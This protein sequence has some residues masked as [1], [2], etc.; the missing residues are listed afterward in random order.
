MAIKK[1]V[2]F[3]VG[4]EIEGEQS[5]A[6]L[7]LKTDGTNTAVRFR[8][9]PYFY[10]ENIKPDEIMAAQVEEEESRL[11]TA[12]TVEPVQLSEKGEKTLLKVH[13]RLPGDVPKLKDY[14]RKFSNATCYEYDIP[15]EKRVVI[16]LQLI[17]FSR[18]EIDV[19]GDSLNGIRMVEESPEAEWK[20]FAFDMEVYNPGIMPDPRKDPIIMISYADGEENKVIS[21][22]GKGESVIK[23]SSEEAL[24]SRFL[25]TV[26][27][28]DPDMVMGY[29]TSVFDIPY[30]LER[31]AALKI[32][33]ASL[34]RERGKMRKI[35]R[36]NVKG[37]DMTGR[38]HLDLYPM[39][40]L[41]GRIGVFDAEK[42]TLYDV[43]KAVLGKEKLMVD[44]A[45]IWEIWDNPEKTEEL[46]KYS[47]MDAQSTYELGMA[48][49]PLEMEI[50]RLS[51][52]FIFDASLGTT[53]QFVENMLMFYARKN[54]ILIPKK[55]NE[56]EVEKRLA[57]PIEGA[58]VKLPEPGIYENIAV[59]D[60][61]GLYPS[62]ITTYNV[63]PYEIRETDGDVHVSPSGTKFAKGPLGLVPSVLK[64]ILDLRI[65]LKGE[66]K[67]AK[68]GT[69]EHEA[70]KA[71]VQA[72]KII[73][74]SFYGYL[75]YP[76]SRWYSRECASSVTAWGR[77]HIKAAEAEA[78]RLGFN[79]LYM[80]T[81]SLFIL[82]NKKTEKD[83]LDFLG[84]MN[85][86]L[87]GDMKLELEE[88]YTRG[89]FV[90]KKGKEAGAKKKYAMLSKNGKIKIRG[91]ELVR[92]DW[93][94]I[95]RE[96]QRAVLDIILREGDKEKAVNY[97]KEVITRLRGN[98]VPLKELVIH[99]QLN[100]DI[101]DYEIISPELGAAKKML[102]KGIK[103]G[104]GTLISYVVTKNGRNISDKA[105]PLDTA[106]NYDAEYYVN[107]QIIPSVLK[108]LKELKVSEQE[109]AN[110]GK[111]SSLSDFFH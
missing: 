74:N 20:S 38:I 62:I 1:G 4:H 93:S 109:L 6:V 96:T 108:L 3:D 97:V 44:R 73:A 43:Y 2:L 42:F 5:F 64:E 45:A 78:E 71:R 31:A 21:T 50:S 59:L 37:Y 18:V 13:C 53:G 15:Y 61:R 9:D 19:D 106:S 69:H 11:I 58:Y 51:K 88:F 56:Q 79:V 102:A 33:G 105:E 80:D 85:A 34:S 87:P 48:L 35:S 89:V 81:D 95:A 32:R 77:A 76:K 36:G 57:N 110:A 49:L 104:M 8:Y 70:L 98:K 94:K 7:H 54:G 25:E 83:V 16:D 41:F 91:F 14:I 82:M 72:L 60:F 103:V 52:T 27:L 12:K 55:P 63:D 28:K 86:K 47:L 30:L 24:I 22:K 68:P 26:E 67:E 107:N 29:N 111:Q 99:T 17:P 40:K 100:K 101:R 65:A 90:T 39:A 84:H 46:V 23:V 92:R 10:A 75:G 66:A